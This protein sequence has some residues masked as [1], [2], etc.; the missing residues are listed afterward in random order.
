MEYTRPDVI[1]RLG[2]LF[3]VVH[4][5]T[6]AHDQKVGESEAKQLFEAVKATAGAP[7]DRIAR[8]GWYTA[9]IHKVPKGSLFEFILSGASRPDVHQEAVFNE[10]WAAKIPEARKE[11]KDDLQRKYWNDWRILR[12]WD[13]SFED[14]KEFDWNKSAEIMESVTKVNGKTDPN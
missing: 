5:W 13:N 7:M 4:S 1:S 12:D 6:A 3:D 2:R 14:L 9:P 11:K 10:G 8:P